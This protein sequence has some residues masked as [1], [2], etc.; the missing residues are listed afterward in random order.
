MGTVMPKTGTSLTAAEL[1]V[2]RAWIST[3]ANP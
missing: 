1:D 2:V 3:G